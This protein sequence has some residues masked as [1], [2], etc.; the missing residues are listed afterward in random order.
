MRCELITRPEVASCLDRFKTLLGVRSDQRAG[1][2]E[3]VGIGLMVRSPDSPTELME[4][5]QSK[6]IGP[7]NDDGVGVGDIDTRLDDCGAHQDVM[8]LVIKIRHNPFECLLTQL[9]VGD[10]NG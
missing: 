2:A 3:K 4:L 9:T 10:S 5:C 6:F 8:V 1:R 7:L